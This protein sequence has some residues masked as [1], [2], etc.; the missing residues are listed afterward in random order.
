MSKL[1]PPTQLVDR[2]Y[3]AYPRTA[4]R[5]SRIPPRAVD[6]SFILS[7]P[8]DRRTLVPN[9]TNAVGGSFILSLRPLPSGKPSAARSSALHTFR[10]RPMAAIADLCSPPRECEGSALPQ[11]I[12]C[13]SS[14]KAQL[15]RHL[16]LV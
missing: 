4:A 5:S 14:E 12:G 15:V 7:L 9:P 6:G 11:N 3:S 8:T 1:Q 2:S 13:C 16:S 10:R